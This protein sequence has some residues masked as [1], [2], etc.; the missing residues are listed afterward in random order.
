MSIKSPLGIAL[1]RRLLAAL[2]VC[3]AIALGLTGGT[4]LGQA[5]ARTATEDFQQTVLPVLSK[6]CLSCHSD[7][8]HS[9][10]LSLE[11]FRTDPSLVMQKP[12]VWA[13][14]LDKVKA[15][16]MPPRSMAPLT[17]DEAAAITGWVERL[18]GPAAGAAEAGPRGANPGRVDPGRVTARRLNR[19]E[20]NNTIRD[21]L[22]V[23]LRPA[24]E[25]PV[26]DSGYGFDNIGDVLSLSPM[27]MEKFVNAARTVSRAAVFGEPYP[28]GPTLIVRLMPKKIQDDMFASGSVTPYSIRGALYANFQAPVDGEYEFRIRYQNF[29][30]TESDG[31]FVLATGAAR[32]GRGGRGAA[33]VP[34]AAEIPD[35]A[36]VPPGAQGAAPARGRGARPSRRELTEEDKKAAYEAARLAIRPVELRLTID[37]NTVYS[38]TVEGNQDYNYARGDSVARV[39]LTA[40][41][42]AV[43][44]SFP[45][46]ADL[47]DPRNHVNPDGRRKLYIDFMDVLG[48]FNATPSAPAGFKKI[49]ICGAPGKYSAECARQIVENLATR[50]YRRPATAQEVERLMG[51]VNE[52]RRRDSFEEAIRVAVQAV[53]M[54]PNFLFRI[55]Q[56]PETGSG[57]VFA[58]GNQKPLPT[59]YLISDY[60]LASRLSYFLWSSMP[61]DELFRAAA[62]KQLRQPGTLDAQVKRMLADPKAETLATNFGEQ[63]LNL[64]LMDRKKPDAAKFPLVDDELLDSMR[65][66]TLL[67]VNAVIREDRSILDFIDGRFT[68]VNGPLARFYGIPGVNGEHFTRV[69]MDGERRSGIVTQGAVLSLSSY[70]TRTSPVIRGKWVLENLLGSVTPPPPDDI[71]ALQEADLGTA[72][73]LR[74]RL[75]QH[76]SDPAC[77]ACHSQMDPIGFG[78]ENFDAAGAWREKDGQFDVDSTGTLPDGRTF[79][80]AKGLKQILLSQSHAFTEN[81]SEK[82]L[83]YALGRGLERADRALV[84]QISGNAVRQHYRFS[85]LVSSI[86]NSP[87]FQMRSI[88]P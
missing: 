31:P 82:L 66:E 47:A 84:G 56:D 83:T 85:S 46:Y 62:Q 50:A 80:G 36:D 78:L 81:F 74:Q 55:E 40:G 48:V 43:R 59:P 37:G 67:F 24:D 58:G 53:L 29:R 13:R 1:W 44:G 14:V 57:G 61:D 60:E 34:D 54:S 38:E 9:G 32:G 77:A 6:S 18:D 73:S 19:A 75:E 5:P 3:A 52:V 2:A 51:L 20:Y 7:R 12:E 39:K 23:S 11:V 26:D 22:G 28:E 30:R 15:G 25:F 16:T 33:A 4:I 49:F 27:L 10:G 8:V 64:R 35:T 86:V 72:A 42:H 21:L 63:W 68:Y 79:T 71:P 45:A 65:R 17:P 69:D 87:A 41:R 88:E 76:R 70:A